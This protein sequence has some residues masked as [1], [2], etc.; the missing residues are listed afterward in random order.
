MGH[1]CSEF[2]QNSK[3]HSATPLQPACQPTFTKCS[4]NVVI[5]QL[6]SHVQH[7]QP[8]DCSTP[9]FPVLQYHPKFAQTHV[10]W[11]GDAIQP[12]HLLS[13]PSLC[14]QSYPASGSFPKN[15]LFTSGGQN[16]GAAASAPVLPMNIQGWFPLVLTSLMSLQPKGLS[17]VFSS[18]TVQKHRFFSAQPSLRSNSH[19]HT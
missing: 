5:V 13:S 10:H 1:L 17:R 11:V 18:T 8:H 2:P 9:G 6:L 16:I 7:C 12:S 3:P 19:I 14:L 4:L 15:W